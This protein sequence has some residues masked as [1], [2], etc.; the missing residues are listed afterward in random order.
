MGKQISIEFKT[1]ESAFFSLFL[2]EKY[3]RIF[4]EVS[5][6][7]QIPNVNLAKQENDELLTF[8]IAVLHI[9]NADDCK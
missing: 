1:G 3:H 6:I 2:M 5:S 9:K 7:F 4:T 8:S